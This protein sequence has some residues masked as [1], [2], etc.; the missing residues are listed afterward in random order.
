METKTG[1]HAIG[2]EADHLLEDSIDRDRGNVLTLGSGVGQEIWLVRETEMD[3]GTEEDRE[4]RTDIVTE[5]VPGIVEVPEI[6]SG[7]VR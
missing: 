6:G 4:T 7:T 3:Q 2:R 5:I 1:A